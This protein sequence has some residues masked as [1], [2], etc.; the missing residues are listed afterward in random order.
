[1]SSSI[2]DEKNSSYFPNLPSSFSKLSTTSQSDVEGS[3]SRWNRPPS[4]ATSSPIRTL[5][6]SLVASVLS[7]S[8]FAMLVRPSWW[9]G[10]A[11]SSCLLLCLINKNLH[12]K[13]NVHAKICIIICI[14]N[15]IHCH[16]FYNTFPWKMAYVT[17]HLQNHLSIKLSAWPLAYLDIYLHIHLNE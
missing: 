17:I 9:T 15:Y 5:A 13:V 10:K 1:M 6:P 4:F 2:D 11:R 14:L 7:S 3:N 8:S 16:I 12:N